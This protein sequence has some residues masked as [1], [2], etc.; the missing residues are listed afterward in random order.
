MSRLVDFAI[1]IAIGL[2]CVGAAIALAEF[3]DLTKSEVQVV[4]K[5]VRFGGFTV[6][7]F[8]VTAIGRQ[9]FFRRPSFW[10]LLSSLLAVH[11]VFLA[12]CR[13]SHLS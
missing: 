10:A 5:W 9:P 12:G 6:I 1:Y 2:T 3:T 11:C 7:V 13:K 4:F 8:V